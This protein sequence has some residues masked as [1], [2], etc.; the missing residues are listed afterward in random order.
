[1]QFHF[2]ME[3]IFDKLGMNLITRNMAMGG[4][5]TIQCEYITQPL[6]LH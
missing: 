5:G 3:P 2:L 1:M 4:L 6:N